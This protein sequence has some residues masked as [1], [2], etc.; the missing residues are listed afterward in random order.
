MEVCHHRRRQYLCH[1]KR[2]FAVGMGMERKRTAGHRRRRHKDFRTNQSGNR[3]QLEK[4]R[5][6]PV[7]CFLHQ[8][9][10]N[11]LGCRRQHQRCARCR[12]RHGAQDTDA[13]RHRQQ[14]EKRIRV[15]VFRTHGHRTEDRR[16]SL[17]VGRRRNRSL[18]LGQL[19]Q[20]NSSETDRNRQE[21][22]LCDDW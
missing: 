6:R 5:S 7:L 9:G 11:T 10:R 14:L 2:R 8:R 4:C 20:P 17:G 16:D 3:Q 21:L 12:R 1:R 18:R 19:C 15:A 13:N 22:G